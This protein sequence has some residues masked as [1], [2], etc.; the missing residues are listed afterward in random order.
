MTRVRNRRSGRHR[1]KVAQWF[2]GCGDGSAWLGMG[3]NCEGTKAESH[4][5]GMTT[6]RRRVGRYT[7]R[8]SRPSRRRCPWAGAAQRLRCGRGLL[9]GEMSRMQDQVKENPYAE[10]SFAQR[11]TANGNAIR[12]VIEVGHREKCNTRRG[13]RMQDAVPRRGPAG[14]MQ[15]R[16]PPVAMFERSATIRCDLHVAAIASPGRSPGRVRS[17]ALQHPRTTVRRRPRISPRR[18]PVPMKNREGQSA[19]PGRGQGP[20]AAATMVEG[21][22]GLR[23]VAYVI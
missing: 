11:C 22:A 16:D 18:S 17:P 19:A 14:A 23:V 3:W 10:L 6:S 9:C 12:T 13:S 1:G 4:L 5:G 21:D 15:S 2:R 20:R 8:D 7:R